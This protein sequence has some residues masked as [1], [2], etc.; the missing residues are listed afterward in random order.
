MYGR[1]V[2]PTNGP[3][4]PTKTV[5]VHGTAPS[6]TN[7]KP[8]PFVRTCHPCQQQPYI[9]L[10]CPCSST[11]GRSPGLSA[12]CVSLGGDSARAYVVAYTH[13]CTY[14]LRAHSVVSPRR[15]VHRHDTACVRMVNGQVIV[16]RR[17]LQLQEQRSC[18]D[19]SDDQRCRH[20]RFGGTYVQRVAL[21][22]GTGSRPVVPSLLQV[23]P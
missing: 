13:T 17:L 19:R 20:P 14:A 4:W 5:C 15:P 10:R 8:W 12:I 6:H 9:R 11:G 23:S 2:S 16:G 1:Y 22:T 7:S 21:G 18:R 3:H